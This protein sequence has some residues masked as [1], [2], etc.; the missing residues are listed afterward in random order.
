MGKCLLTKLNGQIDNDTIL[1]VDE[2]IVHVKKFSGTPTFSTQGFCFRNASEVRIVGDGYFTDKTLSQN[3]GKVKTSDFER[4]YIS[5][6]NFDIYVRSKYN[7]NMFLT[8]ST[9]ANG[10]GSH[11]N[12]FFK[13]D[14]LKYSSKIVHLESDSY[15]DTG[16]LASLSGLVN[17]NV[18]TLSSPLITGDLASLSGLVNCNVFTLSSPLITG[19]LASL[20]GL[21]KLTSIS[22]FSPLITGDLASLK[23]VK[24]TIHLEN[25]NITGDLSHLQ[26]LDVYIYNNIARTYTWSSRP[27]SSNIMSIGGNLFIENIDKMLQ[28]QSV[29]QVPDKISNKVISC[30]GTRTSASDSA[31]E[32]LQEKGYTVSISSPQ[33]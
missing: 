22:L 8:R 25:M 10:G 18:F 20:S 6:G 15:L 24:N 9:E 28:D 16:D 33:Q 27:S 23:S 11:T 29:C 14:E 17:C 32:A 30:R 4:I 2:L 5:D 12:K 3:L 13:I 19:D 1:K 7:I 26:T 31:I 21:T